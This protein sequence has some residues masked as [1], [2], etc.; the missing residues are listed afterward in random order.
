MKVILQENT[1]QITVILQEKYSADEG[2]FTR[3]NTMQL[4]V[5]LQEN[6]VQLKVILQ[7]KYSAVE[8]NFTGKIKCS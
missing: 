4:K 6:T 1:V 7:E 2:N 8:G 3:K 5:I